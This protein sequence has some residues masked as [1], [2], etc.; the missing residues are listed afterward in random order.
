MIPA[1]NLPLPNLLHIDAQ[2]SEPDI[3]E[4]AGS[5]LDGIYVITLEAQIYPVY[6]SRKLFHEITA[7]LW[8]KGFVCCQIDDPNESPVF[9]PYFVEANVSYVNLKLLD[10]NHELTQMLRVLARLG[11][12]SQSR[13]N[14][15]ASQRLRAF[16]FKA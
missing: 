4:G 7:M 9:N 8:E 2:A 5:F 11:E 1:E 6:Q 16:G 15:W 13:F 3:L 14:A 10:E 12:R